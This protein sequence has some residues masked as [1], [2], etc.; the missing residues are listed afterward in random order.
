MNIDKSKPV[1]IT[2]ATGYVAGWIVKRLLDEG[3]TV[4]AAVR[5]P[6]KKD[7]I[8]HLEQFASN[9]SGTIK[10][11][12]AD[13][14]QPGSYTEAMQD[15]ELV[16]HT[17]SPFFMNVKDPQK[18]LIEPAVH[19]TENVLNSASEVGTVKRIV[20]TSSCAAIY[21]DSKD[22][23]GTPNQ[24]FTEE[25]WNTT[26]SITRSPYSYSKK[27]AEE[28]AWELAKAQNA[29]DLVVINPSF[30]VGPGIKAHTNSESYNIIKQ[31]GDGTMKSGLPDLALGCVDV[32]DLAEAHF[33]AG[34]TPEAHGRNIASAENITFL[35]LA[36]MLQD[37]YG[38]KYPIPKKKIAKWL[39]WLIAPMAGFTRQFVSDNVGYDWKADNSKIKRELKMEFRPVKETMNDF[40][41]QLIDTGAFAK[42]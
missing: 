16:F 18:E 25:V 39:V 4:H 17:A 20:L 28:K 33:R 35:G 19:G 29:W 14:T 12:K 10:F 41:Q 6:E 22:L 21:G 15:C 24:K 1:M 37:K 5:S 32:R 7:K 38:S 13:L 8:A 23:L 34:F 40:F 26:S 30:V 27:L 9:S 2:G 36:N 11:F 42:K 3:L 31:M